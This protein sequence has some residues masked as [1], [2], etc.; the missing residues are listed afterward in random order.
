MYY[1]D[2][3]NKWIEIPYFKEF[4]HYMQKTPF[5]ESEKI[6]FLDKQIGGLYSQI[7]NLRH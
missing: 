6:A 1:Y 5:F 7:H 3:I 2:V 4:W